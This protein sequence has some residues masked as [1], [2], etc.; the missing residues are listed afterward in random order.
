M[1]KFK[2]LLAFILILPS[3]YCNAQLGWQAKANYIG[4]ARTL[5]ASFTIGNFG[6]IGCGYDGIFLNDFYKWDQSTNTWS[7]IANYPGQGLWSPTSF[8]INGKGYVGLGQTS[9]HTMA[10]DLWQYDPS[11]NI[12]SPMAT[13]PFTGG[14]DASCFVINNKC[15]VICMSNGGPPYNP[16][17]WVYDASA[18]TWSQKSNFPGGNLEG[19][20]AFAIGKTGY[21][22]GGWDGSNSHNAMWRY[23]TLT[24]TWTSIAP[25]PARLSGI[26]G[27]PRAFVLGSRAYVC[28]GRDATGKAIP[29]G[30]SYDT[31]TK[32][33]CKFSFLGNIARGYGA[34]FTINNKGYMGV[35]SDTNG[36]YFG[37]YVSSLYE[38]TPTSTFLVADTNSCGNDT[39]H[40]T[41]ITTFDSTDMG[42][43]WNWTFTGG[44]PSNSGAQDPSVVYTS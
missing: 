24:D 26:D 32:S 25:I 5:V 27:D 44:N 11:T 14:Y 3:L 39:V 22:G 33:W 19:L 6:Y 42:V 35:G 10:I 23:D 15:Y 29:N 30:F 17:V 4:A 38:Y 34:A 31:V 18:N 40:F 7:A 37:P 28:T 43:N 41:G 16:G 1:R 36:Q 20:V 13:F 9:S 2:T 8:S 21:A 12:W